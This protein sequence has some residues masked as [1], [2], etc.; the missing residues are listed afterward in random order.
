MTRVTWL[1]AEAAQAICGEKPDAAGWRTATIWIESLQHA[2]G[3]LLSFD[4][5]IEVLSPESLRR[6]L[7]TRAERVAALYKHSVESSA[8]RE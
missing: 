1:G 3:L 8:D 5:D 2:A 6:E 4:S 7:A